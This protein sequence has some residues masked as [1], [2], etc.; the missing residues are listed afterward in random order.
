MSTELPT[1]DE[2]EP[3]QRWQQMER[4]VRVGLQKTARE[5]AVKQQIGD[6]IQRVGVVKGLVDKA[7]QASPEAAMAWVGVSF[8]L[9]VLSNPLTEPGINR[10]GLSYV[11]SRMDW[12]WN[13]VDLLLDER[14]GSAFSGLRQQLETRIVQLYPKLLLYQMRSVGL[15]NR[16]R[17]AVFF[18]STPKCTSKRT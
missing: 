8:A 18:N 7:V 1:A 2:T 6:V 15:Y 13:L 12:Y 17:V 11:V 9:E 4:L 14:A 5:A 16:K 3:S 10:K